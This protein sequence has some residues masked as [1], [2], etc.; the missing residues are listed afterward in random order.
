MSLLSFNSK[1]TRPANYR[2]DVLADATT[3]LPAT[4]PVFE[5]RGTRVEA[6][7]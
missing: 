1:Q 3:L 2:G 5:K 4:L 6:T 7:E